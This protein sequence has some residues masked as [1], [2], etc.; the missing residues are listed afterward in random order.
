MNFRYT[1]LS[2]DTGSPWFSTHLG[3]GAKTV[4][5]TSNSLFL[6]RIKLLLAA[7]KLS[8]FDLPRDFRSSKT[9]SGKEG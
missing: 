4:D 9:K 8:L 5:R 2:E 1:D 6:W 3:F 7:V